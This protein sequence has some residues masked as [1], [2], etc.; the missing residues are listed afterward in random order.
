MPFYLCL[1]SPRARTKYMLLDVTYSSLRFKYVQNLYLIT[2][3]IS[4]NISAGLP[5]DVKLINE[6]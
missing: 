4:V 2:S 6:L 1:S 3:L 5:E